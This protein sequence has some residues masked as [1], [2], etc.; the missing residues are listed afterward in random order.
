LAVM[1]ADTS[2]MRPN[3]P[4]VMTNLKTQQ[5]VAEVVSYIENKGLLNA[6]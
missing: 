6:A 2:R 4:F 3:R 5:G 1:Q